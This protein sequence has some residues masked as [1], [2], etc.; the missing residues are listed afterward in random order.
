[1]D[2]QVQVPEDAHL[3]ANHNFY[4]LGEFFGITDPQERRDNTKALDEVLQ[5]AQ[6]ESKSQE[7]IDVL[8]H[9]RQI[10][11]TLGTDSEPRLT[12]LRRYIALQEDQN[13]LNKEME[14]LK[15]TPANE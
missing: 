3:L 9:I 13:R 6:K 14:L 12:K 7:L 2:N 15:G 1:M 8:L 10:E 5:W 4:R 11:R